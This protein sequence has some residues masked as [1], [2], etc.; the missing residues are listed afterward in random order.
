MLLRIILYTKE[1]NLKINC[2]ISQK[3][4]ALLIDLI[5]LVRMTIE[6]KLLTF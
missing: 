1:R 4:N 6:E 5:I 3:L 2:L